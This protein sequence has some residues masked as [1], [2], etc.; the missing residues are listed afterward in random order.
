MKIK[1][2]KTKPEPKS[3][4]PE[5]VTPTQIIVQPQQEGAMVTMTTK[6]SLPILSDNNAS[7]D[8]VR[9][10]AKLSRLPR[11]SCN[12]CAVG[13]D[14]PEYKPGHVCAFED[15]FAAFPLRTIDSALTVMREVAE[16]TKVR[17]RRARLTEELVSGGQVDPVVTKLGE[18]LMSQTEKIV[19]MSRSSQQVSVT[20]MGQQTGG[21][22][23]KLFGSSSEPVVQE[24]ITLNPPGVR[25]PEE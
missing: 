22:L 2:K 16:G 24:V 7:V 17:Y 18:V 20:V 23:S 14:C 1:L 6:R 15:A 25:G 10:D 19:E 21:L 3:P 12:S 13:A 9:E 5:V 11:F 4:E 8:L